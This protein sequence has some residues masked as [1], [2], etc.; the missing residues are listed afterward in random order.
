MEE[1]NVISDNGCGFVI[2]SAGRELSATERD[3]ISAAAW[4]DAELEKTRDAALDPS[5]PLLKEVLAYRA[6]LKLYRDNGYQGDRPALE[7]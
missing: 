1:L 6:A 4:V 3:E 7:V 5:Y 2:R